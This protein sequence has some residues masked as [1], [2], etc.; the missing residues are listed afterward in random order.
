MSKMKELDLHAEAIANHVKE[1]LEE[2]Y[3]IRIKTFSQ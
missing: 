1:I 3:T 2:Y